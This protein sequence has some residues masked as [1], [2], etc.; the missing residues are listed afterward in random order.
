MSTPAIA[1]YLCFCLINV[2]FLTKSLARKKKTFKLQVP[3]HPSPLAIQIISATSSNK[4]FLP[5]KLKT[6][7][8]H[9]SKERGAESDGSCGITKKNQSQAYL[10]HLDHGAKAETYPNFHIKAS[11]ISFIFPK[12]NC[13]SPIL[14]KFNRE[15]ML[16]SVTSTFN[17]ISNLYHNA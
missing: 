3:I 2:F 9:L 7:L 5:L 10:H 6:F 12:E 13:L 1:F 17:V 16:P 11:S 8:K 14:S 15:L 4:N